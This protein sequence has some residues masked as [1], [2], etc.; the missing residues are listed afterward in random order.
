MEIVA[1]DDI[2][3]NIVFLKNGVSWDVDAVL[4]L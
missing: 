3:G 4:P 2:S 1:G